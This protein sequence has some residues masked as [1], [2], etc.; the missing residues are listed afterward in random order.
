MLKMSPSLGR[1]FFRTNLVGWEQRV[2]A[3]PT[4]DYWSAVRYVQYKSDGG[5]VGT[6]RV[7]VRVVRVQYVLY[8]IAAW[9]PGLTGRSPYL[10]TVYLDG[11]QPRSQLV[12][13]HSCNWS[14]KP[15]ALQ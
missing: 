10:R 7:R 12:A 2:S 6:V 13:S 8:P 15:E 11:T 9:P 1:D 3:V 14:S 5:W 4:I